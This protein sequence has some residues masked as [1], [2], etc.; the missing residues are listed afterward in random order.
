MKYIWE[1]VEKFFGKSNFFGIG[2]RKGSIFYDDLWNLKYLSKFRW[3]HLTGQLAYERAIREQRL[4]AEISRT[5]RENEFYLRQTDR[6][7]GMEIA[8]KRR[9]QT[10]DIPIFIAD[11]SKGLSP[12][13]LSLYSRKVLVVGSESHGLSDNIRNLFPT[14]NSIKIP[15]HSSVESLNVS[16]ATS[17]LM[18]NS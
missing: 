4:N 15:M 3:S 5:K 1:G 13:I 10:T 18:A 2:T 7:H 12:K 6:A 11:P 9:K 8:A 14:T 16:I 17:I